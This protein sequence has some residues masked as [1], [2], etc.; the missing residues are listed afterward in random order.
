M[1][2]TI[3]DPYTLPPTIT[4]PDER[5]RLLREVAQ[6][7]NANSFTGDPPRLTREELHERR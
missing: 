3:H 1:E 7:M 6:N 5:A 4:D 2:I